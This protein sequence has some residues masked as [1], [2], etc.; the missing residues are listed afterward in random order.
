MTFSSPT[1]VRQLVVMIA[2]DFILAK[3]N[4]RYKYKNPS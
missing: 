1:V 4:C 3:D 2:K